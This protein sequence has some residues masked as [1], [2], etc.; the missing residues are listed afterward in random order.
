[1]TKSPKTER[2]AEPDPKRA[3]LEIYSFVSFLP[4]ALDPAS[5]RAANAEADEAS[6]TLF[7]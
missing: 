7:D 5:A 3:S 4:A 6:P 1:M 2:E